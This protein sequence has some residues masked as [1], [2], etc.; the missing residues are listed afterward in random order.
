VLLEVTKV[1][2]VGVPQAAAWA[3][4]SDV[5]RLSGCIPKL[6][7][8]HVV[9]PD[10]QYAA[11]VS[12]RLGPFSLQVPVRIEVQQVEPPRRITAALTG[13][14]KRGLARIRGTLEALAAQKDDHTTEL[15]LSMRLEVLGKLATLGA[16]PMRR[17]ADEI[18]SE[19]AARVRIELGAPTT[20]QV[21]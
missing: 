20:E 15:S 16:L 14:D 18:F 3:L 8:F 21:V 7:D 17:R 6:S 2:S 5:P 10:A 12:D 9:V 11:V 4:L 13:D 19:F 1:T